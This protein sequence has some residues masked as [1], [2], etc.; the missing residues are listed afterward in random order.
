MHNIR[1]LQLGRNWEGSEDQDE[2][3]GPFST[4]FSFSLF[5]FCLVL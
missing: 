4:T 2:L 3:T 5:L 1:F